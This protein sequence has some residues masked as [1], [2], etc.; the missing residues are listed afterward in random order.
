MKGAISGIK[1]LGNGKVRVDLG[2]GKS[3]EVPE[4]AISK[5][6][7]GQ[8]FIKEQCTAPSGRTYNFYGQKV[9]LDLKFQTKS[10]TITTNREWMKKGNNPYVLDANGKPVS[11]NQHHSQQNVNGPI[12][13]IKTTTHQN[14]TNQQVLHPYKKSG[15]GVNTSYPVTEEARKV[16]NRKDRPYINKER[17]K[18]LEELEKENR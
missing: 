10:G 17:V 9:D 3:V 7:S 6:S 4:G 12:F 1:N 11:T 16:W 18:R 5:D 8:I 2:G 14:K 13:E 15:D